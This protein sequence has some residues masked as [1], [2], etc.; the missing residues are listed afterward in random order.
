MECLQCGNCREVCPVFGVLRYEG[1]STRG[2]LL[3][4]SPFV[5]WI[6]TP[7]SI[8]KN[9]FQCTRCL[10]CRDVCPVPVDYPRIL[11]MVRENILRSG[12]GY[13]KHYRIIQNRIVHRNPYGEKWNL[14]KVVEGEGKGGIRYFPGCTSVFRMN[15]VFESTIIL[16]KRMYKKIELISDCCKVTEENESMVTSC[17]GCYSSFKYKGVDITHTAQIFEERMDEFDIVS[18]PGTITYHD[19]CHLGRHAN[20][21]DAPREIL[22]QFDFVE[23]EHYREN[24]LCCGAGG[25]VKS[26]FPELALSMAKRRVKEAK[27]ARAEFIVTP[28]PFCA[29]N[30]RDGGGNVLDLSELL[31]MAMQ[32]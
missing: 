20:L 30:L 32:E 6:S 11:N 2:R 25:G 8:R 9:I 3:Q 18:F 12:K 1:A 5:G 21:Y 28:C 23:M 14:P 7:E 4:V 17:A 26:A 31:V 22:S 15:S 13:E 16:L 24:S 10:A 19:P 27:D 29:R